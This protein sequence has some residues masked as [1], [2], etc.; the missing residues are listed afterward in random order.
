MHLFIYLFIY[1]FITLPVDVSEHLFSDIALNQLLT[2]LKKEVS[3]HSRHLHQ[4]FQVFLAYAH[5]GAY[6]VRTIIIITI[7]IIIIIIT[8]III[9]ILYNVLL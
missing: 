6:E 2:L 7:I 9:I 4:Y 3:D 8:I 1:L 5:K